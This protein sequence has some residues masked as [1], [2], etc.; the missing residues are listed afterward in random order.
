MGT[1]FERTLIESVY[2]YLDDRQTHKVCTTQRIW[3]DKKT[4]KEVGTFMV[5]ETCKDAY[6]E[7]FSNGDKIPVV[8]NGGKAQCFASYPWHDGNTET[9]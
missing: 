6:L 1:F 8:V 9:S 5:V 7:E 2:Q 3:S 4:G